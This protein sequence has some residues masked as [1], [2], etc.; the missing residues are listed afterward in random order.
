M[1]KIDR[2]RIKKNLDKL[3]V[4]WEVRS[5]DYGRKLAGRDLIGHVIASQT[6]FPEHSNDGDLEYTIIK[7]VGQYRRNWNR[8]TG[9]DLSKLDEMPRYDRP[10]TWSIFEWPFRDIW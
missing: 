7:Y 5:R 1:R 3:N 2:E 4:L 9:I 10:S 6:Y 8:E